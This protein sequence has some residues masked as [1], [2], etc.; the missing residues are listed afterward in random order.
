MKTKTF[1]FVLLTILCSLYTGYNTWT[2]YDGY[3]K[4]VSVWNEEA[5]DAFEE[6]LWMEVGKRSEIPVYSLSNGE[7]GWT[8][9]SSVIPDSVSV[10]TKDGF[11]QYRIDQSKYENSLLVEA[12]HRSRL[13]TLF[14]MHP[15]TVDTLSVHW[16]SLLQTKH[17][18]LQGQIRYVYTDLNLRNDTVFSVVDRQLAS[19]DSLTVKYLGFR[20]EHEVTAYISYPNWILNLACSD[21]FVLLFPWILFICLAVYWTKLKVW[22]KGRFTHEIMKEKD[23]HVVD[24]V[25]DEAGIF[26]LP[27][28]TIF[29]SFVASVCKDGVEQHLQPQ[30]AL[31]LKLL[32]TKSN[33]KVT[34]EEIS[35]ELWHETREKQKLYSAVQ[36]LRNDLRAVGS[37]VVI[38]C[39]NGIYELKL[40][41]SS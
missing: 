27:D 14:S 18:S 31:L 2:L 8:T 25:M 4:Q 41:I 40:P 20:C 11:R 24:V 36:R 30:S 16:D 28:G 9:L 1:I 26:K 39:T 5:K 7:K 17:F 32:L 34:S 23:I 6:A 33:Y 38:S 13:S 12:R 19:L 10:M 21:W 22:V 37:E 35:M 3:R 15:L 29:N